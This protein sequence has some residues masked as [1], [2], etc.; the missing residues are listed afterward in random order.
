MGVVGFF[1]EVP[2][3][4]LFDG[5]W[6]WWGGGEVGAHG[7]EAVLVSGVGDG[8]LAAIGSGESE[9]SIGS[10]PS[11]TALSGLDIISGFVTETVASISVIFIYGLEDWDFLSWRLVR[12]MS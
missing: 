3:D 8:V 2:L 1:P 5:L 12:T 9:A 6:D 7:V 10:L 4:G 11:Q